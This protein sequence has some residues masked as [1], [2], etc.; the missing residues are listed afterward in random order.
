ME[1]SERLSTLLDLTQDKIVLIDENGSYKYAN[2]AVERLLGY[3]PEEF[4]GLNAFEQIHPEDIEPVRE[5][6]RRLIVAERDRTDTI[7]YRHRAKDGSW[8][9]LES[10]MLNRKDTTLDGYV[11]SSR[12]ISD[13][14]E[15]EAAHRETKRR[16]QELAANAKDVLWMFTADWEEVLFVNDAYE[17]VYGQSVERVEEDA[18]GFLEAIHPDDREAATEAMAR[19]SAGESIETEY[20]VHPGRNYQRWVWVQAQ[21]IIEDGEVTRIVGFSRDITDR[22][23]REQQLRVMDNLLRHNLRND[24]SV[25]MGHAELAREEGGPSV[26]KNMDTILETGTD[27]LTTAEKE[28]EIVDT[29]I[30]IESPQRLDMCQVVRETAEMARSTFPDAHIDVE[31]PESATAVALPEIERALYELLENAAKHADSA[32]E[33]SI[34][35]QTVGENVEI[36][37]VDNGPQIPDYEVEPLFGTAELS[38]LFHGTGLGLWVVYWIVDFSDGSLQFEPVGDGGNRVTVRLPRA[39]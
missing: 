35:V 33:I 16:L 29:L 27:L 4:V 23:R 7:E 26:A 15:A 3:T 9:W 39:D 31:A 21:P 6:F 24:L 20:R 36:V 34:R 30:D 19:V 10:R 38:D 8:V 37:F 17:D 2:A 1:D 18:A 22:R 32:P 5:A 14:K 13:R 12:D 11:V 25:I 28:R